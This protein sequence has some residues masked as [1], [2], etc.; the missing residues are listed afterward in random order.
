MR[1][2]EA[3]AAK[4]AAMVQARLEI[5]QRLPAERELATQFCVSRPT[6][7]EAIL[8]LALVGMLEVRKN[9]GVYVLSRHERPRIKDVEGFGPFEMLAARQ[10]V[11]PQLAAIAARQATPTILAQLADALAMMRKENAQG[12]EAD[13]GDHRFH[14]TVAEATGNGALVAVCDMLWTAQ[15]ESRIWR[16]I[17]S[18]MDIKT[19]WPLWIDDHERI[20]EAIRAGDPKA[21][22]NAMNRHLEH[23]HAV[24]MTQSAFN[25]RGEAAATP[26]R[27]TR[28]KKPSSASS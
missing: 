3:V 2:F 16:E 6:I 10:M 4:I 24:L 21:A 14:V 18:H 11:E 15:V 17:Y 8:S 20:Y 28:K 1:S 25:G 27:A 19:F 26:A 13:I 7:R 23:V 5:G 12:R 9:V 22:S